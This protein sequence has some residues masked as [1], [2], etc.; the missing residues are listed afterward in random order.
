MTGSDHECVDRAPTGLDSP[1]N[2]ITTNVVVVGVGDAAPSAAVQWAATEAGRRGATLQLLMAYDASATL[3]NR[4]G[5]IPPDPFRQARAEG[6]EALAA[7]QASLAATHPGLPVTTNLRHAIAHRALVRASEHALLTVVG[8]RRTG[9]ART[10]L[11]GSIAG[12]VAAA[13]YGPVAVIP[14]RTAAPEAEDGGPVW[15]GLD[16]SADSNDALAFALQEASLR[17]VPLVAIHSW[18][19]QPHGALLTGF[20]LEAD[21]LRRDQEERLLAEQLAGWSEKYPEVK[22]AARM[23]RGAPDESIV[24]YSDSIT[25]TSRPALL[26]LGSRGRNELTNLLL[27]STSQALIAHGPCP[28]VVARATARS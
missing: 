27:G 16:G 5:A 13:A 12:R 19:D 26:V 2:A 22:V 23:L 24:N 7:V 11:L 17:H 9:T 25:S 21:R 18:K 10:A 1:M 8:S 4:G 6:L 14:N 15:V 28:V 20:P 3:P